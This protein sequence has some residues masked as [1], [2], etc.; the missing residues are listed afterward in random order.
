VVQKKMS[1]LEKIIVADFP[2]IQVKKVEIGNDEENSL[3]S[4]HEKTG[5]RIQAHRPLARWA[6]DKDIC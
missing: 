5:D 1:H 2:G 4:E 6:P 3:I